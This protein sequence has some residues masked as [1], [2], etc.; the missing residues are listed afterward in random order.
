M[1]SR[2]ASQI[3]DPVQ[4]FRSFSA[5]SRLAGLVGERKDVDS[6][7]AA[8]PWVVL[9]LAGTELQQRRRTTSQKLVACA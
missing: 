8:R 1:H 5:K 7:S 2:P 3:M 9:Q 4:A 6:E